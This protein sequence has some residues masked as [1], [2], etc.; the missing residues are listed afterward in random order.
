MIEYIF[1]IIIIIYLVIISFFIFK[2]KGKQYELFEYNYNDL[3]LGNISDNCPNNANGNFYCLI[4]WKTMKDHYLSSI[5]INEISKDNYYTENYWITILDQKTNTT[6]GSV[7]WSYLYYQESATPDKIKTTVPYLKSYVTAASGLLNNLQNCK[8]ITD[9]RK[10]VRK[11]HFFSD[12]SQN[13]S[14]M[15]IFNSSM[16]K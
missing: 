5:S 12:H 4:K 11:V 7:R 10:D 1:L 9:F 14:L 6:V 15:Q 3:C 16:N 13:K 8:I 2:T